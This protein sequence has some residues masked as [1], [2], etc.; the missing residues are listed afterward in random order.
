MLKW[1]IMED[2]AAKLLALTNVAWQ[3]PFEIAI[4]WAKRN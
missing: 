4:N 2:E 3:E 1:T